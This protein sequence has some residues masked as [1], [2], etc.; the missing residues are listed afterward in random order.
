MLRLWER[1]GLKYSEKMQAKYLEEGYSRPH[2][3]LQSV[4]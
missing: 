1:S 4:A 2:L 3:I